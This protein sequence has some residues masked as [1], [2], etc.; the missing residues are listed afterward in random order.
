MSQLWI[1]NFDMEAIIVGSG[2]PQCSPKEPPPPLALFS[3]LS[4]KAGPLFV[5][6]PQGTMAIQGRDTEPPGGQSHEGRSTDHN[7]PGLPGPLPDSCIFCRCS[8]VKG[9]IKTSQESWRE[10]GLQG[11][12]LDYTVQGSR[13]SHVTHLSRE[14]TETG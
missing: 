12:R 9:S 14:G 4:P 7:L 1:G 8:E 11:A 2:W 5:Q 6:C 3:F 10:I 13:E